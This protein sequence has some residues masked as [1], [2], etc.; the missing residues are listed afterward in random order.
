MVTFVF[1]YGLF[2]WWKNLGLSEN[3]DFARDRLVE[4]FMCTVGLSFEPQYKCLRKS[5]TKVVNFI[6]IVDDVYDVYG[7]LEELR[8]FTNAVDRSVIHFVQVTRD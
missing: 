1:L 4:S 2:S 7:S 6:L 3:L 5:L 8:H